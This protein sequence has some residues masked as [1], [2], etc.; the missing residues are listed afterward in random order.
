[1]ESISLEL[2]IMKRDSVKD[3]VIST[4]QRWDYHFETT[5]SSKSAN[6]K[7]FYITEPDETGKL[8]SKY[9]VIQ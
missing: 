7:L 1:M 2:F 5:L 8:V 4:N 9:F 3:W 6:F